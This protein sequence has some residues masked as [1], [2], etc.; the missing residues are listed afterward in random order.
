MPCIVCKPLTQ[1]Q[2][3][4]AHGKVRA[5]R[6]PEC[7]LYVSVLTGSPDLSQ[8]YLLSLENQCPCFSID[9]IWLC[10][11]TGYFIY[12]YPLSLWFCKSIQP[13]E[14]HQHFLV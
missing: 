12:C 2:Y 5:Y 9:S 13:P 7:I 14:S 3:T 6:E 11:E 1:Q 10:K 4:E 8:V